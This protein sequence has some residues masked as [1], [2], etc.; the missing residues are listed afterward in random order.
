MDDLLPYSASQGTLV[1]SKSA[2]GFLVCFGDI[3]DSEMWVSL[4]E[5]AYAKLHKGYHKLVGGWAAKAL[6]D[7]TEGVTQKMHVML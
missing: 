2:T 6:M 7:L 5:K 4:L 3:T 1:C